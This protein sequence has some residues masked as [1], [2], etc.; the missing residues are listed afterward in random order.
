M[1]GREAASAD[2]RS[3]CSYIV[4]V[5]RLSLSVPFLVNGSRFAY[6][7]VFAVSIS[8]DWHALDVICRMNRSSA[9]LRIEKRALHACPSDGT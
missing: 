6:P 3:V 9:M 5:Q 7:F 1:F 8:A 2:L 4:F